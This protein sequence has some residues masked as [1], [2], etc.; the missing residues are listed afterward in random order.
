L[1]IDTQ[2]P[3]DTKGRYK[4]PFGDFNRVHRCA[5]LSAEGAGRGNTSTLTSNGQRRVCTK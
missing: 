4:F 3:E 2:H 1:G 5:A